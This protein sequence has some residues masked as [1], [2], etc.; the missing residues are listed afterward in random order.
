[1][2][3]A[4]KI[5]IMETILLVQ[6][7]GDNPFGEELQELGRFKNFNDAVDMAMIL[8]DHTVENMLINDGAQWVRIR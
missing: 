2:L 7:V 8:I 3:C 6:F 4:F 5:T 1:M